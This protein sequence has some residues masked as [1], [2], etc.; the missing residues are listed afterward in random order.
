VKTFNGNSVNVSGLQKGEYLV[1][2]EDKN[3]VTTMK[4]I[5]K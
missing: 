3:G 5:K 4:F 1:S 2:I